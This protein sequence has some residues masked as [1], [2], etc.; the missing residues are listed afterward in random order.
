MLVEKIIVLFSQ[1]I[2]FSPVIITAIRLMRAQSFS[3]TSNDNSQ[4]FLSPSRVPLHT[5]PPNSQLAGWRYEKN[6][7]TA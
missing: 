2:F 6:G 5:I 3:L 1:Q 4:Q 7:L